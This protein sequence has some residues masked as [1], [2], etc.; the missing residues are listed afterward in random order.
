[1]GLQPAL[2]MRRVA[3]IRPPNLYGKVSNTFAIRLPRKEHELQEAGKNFEL[4]LKIQ[5][6]M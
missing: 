3:A 6:E 4:L 1:M 2:S 5:L